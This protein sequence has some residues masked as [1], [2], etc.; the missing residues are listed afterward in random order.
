MQKI[1]SIKGFISVVICTGLAHI[2]VAQIIP[3]P[4]IVKTGIGSFTYSASTIIHF[5]PSLQATADILQSRLKQFNASKTSISK[6]TI[7]LSIDSSRVKQPEAYILDIQPA[8]I[9]ITG[10]D[11]AGV[12][13][14]SQSL[15]QLLLLSDNKWIVKTGIIEDYPRFGYRGMHLDVGRHFY[16]VSFIKK[17]I[18][19]LSLYK[20]NTFHWHLTEDQGWRIAI[21]RYPRLA[22]VAAY[23]NETLIGHK[24]NLP[25]RFDGK[26]Y[27]GYYSQ[28]EIRDVV[29]YAAERHVEII[30]EIEMPG[31]ALAALS[32]YPELGCTGGPYKAATFW[33]VFDDVFC[34][35]N[36]S[37]FTFLQNVLDEVLLLFPSRYIHIGGDECPK[38]R[39]AKC[40]KCQARIKSEGL[41]GEHELQS[42]FIR[43]I[44]RY[45]NSKGRQIIGWDEILEG[46]LAPGAT[47]MSWRGEAGGI[48]AAKEKHDVIMTPENIVYFDHAES[49]HSSEKLSIGGYTPLK[50]VYGYEPLPRELS[51]D[52]HK[53]IKG[54]QGN[55]WT[56]YLKSGRDVEYNVF[57]RAIAL[58]EIAWTTSKTKNYNHFLQRLR[59][60]KRMLT[61]LQVNYADVFDEV[62][63]N[64]ARSDNRIEL[65]LESTLPDAIIKYTLDSSDPLK[66]GKLYLSSIPLEKS[67]VI[68]VQAFSGAK[69]SGRMLELTFHHHKGTGKKV[70]LTNPGQ[71]NYNPGNDALT[72]GFF[73]NATYNNGQWVGLSGENLEA[74]IDLGAEQNISEVG[75]NVLKYHWQRMWEPVRLSFHLSNDGKNF[76]EVFY[77]DSFPVNGINSIRSKIKPQKARYVKVVGINKGIIPEGEYGAGARAWM[78]VDE[79][80]VN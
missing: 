18:D 30:P 59:K 74:I 52:Q 12:F 55:V 6:N 1:S 61:A 19:L 58:A 17:Y 60:H 10:H 67:S 69:P 76:H 24:R 9:N 36:D 14:G 70:T 80:L 26:K 16:P 11:E 31:H 49:I 7:R 2:G 22:E 63:Y 27:G 47:V 23:R 75:I 34:A 53:Y 65:S 45:L 37:V 8:I 41:K 32:A 78:M 29:K 44:E 62:T 20:F 56:E 3:A 33:G 43:R 21:D 54:I 40:P 4:A 25:H 15:L 46:G 68:K 42:Y 13:Y 35:G 79:I 5:D 39:W 50:E 28:E 72:N 66:V 57:P 48:A 77:T 51:S 73:G 71:G 38:Y 64:I